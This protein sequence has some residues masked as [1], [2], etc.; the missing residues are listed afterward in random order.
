V[1]APRLYAEEL[2]ATA[3]AGETG[4]S[5][6]LREVILA[7]LERP[8]SPDRSD[9][10]RAARTGRWGQLQRGQRA[11]LPLGVGGRAATIAPSG[12]QRH[13]AG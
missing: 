9:T 13:Y 6:S 2:A 11:G 7:R 8:A 1:V 3:Q 10:D 4:L 12:R 5:T